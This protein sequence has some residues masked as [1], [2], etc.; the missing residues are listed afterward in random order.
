MANLLN[1]HSN[2]FEK[3]VCPYDRRPK[4]TLIRNKINGNLMQPAKFKYVTNHELSGA[5]EHLKVYFKNMEI[6]TS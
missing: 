3:S 6:P 4:D 2:Y 1:I 5:R